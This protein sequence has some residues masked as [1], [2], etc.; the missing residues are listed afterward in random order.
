MERQ[1]QLR[2]LA[3]SALIMVVVALSFNFISGLVSSDA[4]A[5]P[6]LV[7]LPGTFELEDY[8][9]FYDTTKG[10]SGRAYRNDDV[11][12][13]RCYDYA[14]RDACYSVGW[15]TPGEWVGFNVTVA[16]SGTFTFSTRVASFFSGQTF[17]FEVD[18]VN[19][20][21]PIEAPN[22]RS[23]LRWADVNSNP[24]Q[25]LAG[26]HSLR[27][28]AD[29]SNFNLN[30]VTVNQLT[31]DAA[32]QPAQPTPTTQPTQVP[33]TPTAEPTQVPRLQL[34][35]RRRSRQPRLQNRPR[36]QQRRRPI[37]PRPDRRSRRSSICQGRSR[38]STTRAT[39]TRHPVTSASSSAATMSISRPAPTRPPTVRATTSPGSS[40]T[41]G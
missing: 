38:L 2:R 5:A 4:S 31:A 25:L 8:T 20:T 19:V 41:S 3:H 17:H 13:Q 34:P 27:L 35:S 21:G 16:N 10:N 9:I 28:V 18:G 22:T 33:A 40:R 7:A 6:G 15:V 1:T 30:S 37:R 11:D 12:I 14:S 39:P 29:G 23:M 24:V 26:N 32:P 36:F